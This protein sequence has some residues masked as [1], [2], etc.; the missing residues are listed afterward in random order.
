MHKFRTL[1]MQDYTKLIK[2][3]FPLGLAT[4]YVLGFVVVGF[5]LAGYGAP[6][7]DLIKTQYLAAGFWF[8][9]VLFLYFGGLQG[10]R[11]IIGKVL[12]GV[13]VPGFRKDSRWDE[14]WITLTSNVSIAAFLGGFAFIFVRIPYPTERGKEFT[15]VVG[16][17]ARVLWL[18]VF[19]MAL[20]DIFFR[21]RGWFL[22]RAGEAHRSA[23]TWMLAWFSAT[24]LAIFFFVNCI[25]IFAVSVYRTIPFSLGGGQPRQVVFWLGAGTGL[26]DS[27]L[28]RD[29]PKPYTIPYELLVESESSLVVISPKEGQRAIEF[30]RKAVSAMVVLGKRPL[31]APEHFQREINES[32]PKP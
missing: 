11:S 25:F 23:D 12:S 6:S 7:L 32:P 27:F 1:M 10:I 31:T 26:A 5:H 16:S 8:C 24:I 28:E 29:G 2:E 21:L 14:V 3:W 20:L 9:S 4:V 19:S 13:P 30:D 22:K 18:L 17:E 15:R